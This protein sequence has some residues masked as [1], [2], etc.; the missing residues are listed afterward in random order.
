MSGSSWE[1]RKIGEDRMELCERGT[2]F[3]KGG[4]IEIGLGAQEGEPFSR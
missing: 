4:L 2:E 3:G 1:K